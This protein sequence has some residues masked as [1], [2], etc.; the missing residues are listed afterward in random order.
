MEAVS[1]QAWKTLGKAIAKVKADNPN[2]KIRGNKYV[3]SK[4][5]C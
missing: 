2:H 1:D 5:S 4:R 3:K